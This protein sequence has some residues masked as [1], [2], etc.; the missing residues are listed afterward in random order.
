[1]SLPGVSAAAILTL[2]WSASAFLGPYLLGQPAQYTVAVEVER[3]VHEDLNWTL[4]A[5]LNVV[6]IAILA[7]G[8]YVLSL[9][10]RRL[11]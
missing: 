8:A 7:G 11:A 3:Q 10:R 1:M 6:L 2:L 5:A 9:V 4:G